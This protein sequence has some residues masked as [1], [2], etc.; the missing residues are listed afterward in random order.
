M[1][2]TPKP[3]TKK[4]APAKKA[5]SKIAPRPEAKEAA[6]PARSRKAA[7]PKA[8]AKLVAAEVVEPAAPTAA[9]IAA[10]PP[11]ER[12]AAAKV[13]N[14][15]I[16]AEIKTAGVTRAAA[17]EALPTPVLDW[18]DANPAGKRAATVKAAK[19]GGGARIKVDDAVLPELETLVKSMRA[20]KASW[21]AIAAAT[22]ALPT[23]YTEN[24]VYILAKRHGW[25]PAKVA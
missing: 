5:G 19:S 13:E 9:Q 6:K 8:D 21:K 16:K 18:M 4:A 17:R 10:M 23:Q 12:L 24:Q 7:A 14:E 25:N 3:T 2:T 1:T 11:A 22:S 15:A 20:D